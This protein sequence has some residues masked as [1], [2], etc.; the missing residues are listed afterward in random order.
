MHE[1]TVERGIDLADDPAFSHRDAD[2]HEPARQRLRGRDDVGVD[3]LV[4]IREEPPRA[5]DA[6]L[7]LVADQERAVLVQHALRGREK[8]RRR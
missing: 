6:R 8:A 7:D 5:S 2:R 1:G 3:T 4:L